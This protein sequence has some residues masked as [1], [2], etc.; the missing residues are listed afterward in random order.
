MQNIL[1][2]SLHNFIPTTELVKAKSDTSIVSSVASDLCG[3]GVCS[4]SRSLEA[5]A[6]LPMW[7][8]T[9]TTID[10]IKGDRG[11]GFSV[12]DYQVG[13][14]NSCFYKT[15]PFTF[16]QDPLNPDKTVIVVRS[17]VPGGVAQ[18]DGR[19][20]PGD[21]LVAVNTINVEHATLDEAVRV[22]KGAP[23]GVVRLAVAKPLN[24]NET[25]SYTSQVSNLCIYTVAT[26]KS[27]LYDIKNC[28]KKHFN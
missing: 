16:S 20:I 21:K 8:D 7:S 14:L 26:V 2:G 22:L 6:G 27:G 12:L 9:I 17:L 23:K 4:R 25:A 1:G 28:I 10:L 3:S 19:L 11:L 18:T 15:Q 24:T 13:V 5:I